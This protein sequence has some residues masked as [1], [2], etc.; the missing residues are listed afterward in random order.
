MVNTQNVY[1][2]IVRIIANNQEWDYLNPSNTI[3]TEPSIGSGFFIG[4]NIILT[5]AHVIDTSKTIIFSV[6]SLSN[7]KY[8]A[9]IFGICLNLDI[10]ILKSKKYSSNVHLQL[11]N[12][13][14][15]VLQDNIKV[16]GFPLG[17]DKIK[18]TKG[19]ISGVQDG[20]IQIDSAINSGNS[21]GP[22]LNSSNNVI[23]II[24]SKVI[25]AENIGYATPINLINIFSNISSNKKVYNVCNFMAKFSNTS[26]SRIEYINKLSPNKKISSGLTVSR[27][28]NTSPLVQIG[29]EVG[30]LIFNFDNKNISNICELEIKKNYKMVITDYI[31]RLSPGIEYDI[32]YFSLKNKQIFSKKI[33]FSDNNKNIIHKLI[34]VFDKLDYLTIGGIILSPITINLLESY[35]ISYKIRKYV[36]GIEKFKPKIVIVNIMPDS[37]FNISENL[38]IGDVIDTINDQ[39][40]TTFDSLLNVLKN[41]N[42]EYLTIS[43]L[44]GKLD[45]L[46]MANI[47]KD[48]DII[49]QY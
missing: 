38:L 34:P 4:N 18:I 42:S 48:L 32:S 17:R 26:D 21:G 22:L 46:S 36:H 37:P 15:I 5:C 31:E 20:Y 2:S 27:V 1:N 14:N 9:E 43:T 33:V 35:K 8:E 44:S 24:T 29:I 41:F 30:D 49:K 6:P 40:I 28:V 23:G 45:T 25:D 7:E 12:S 11:T 3:I 39:K 16:I 47:R 13:D 19:I 10:A